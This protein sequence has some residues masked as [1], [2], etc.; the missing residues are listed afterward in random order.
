M[1][2]GSGRE[3]GATRGRGLGCGAGRLA[4]PRE[5]A[6]GPNCGMA[7]RR[8]TA[9][10]SELGTFLSNF[11]GISLLARALSDLKATKPAASALWQ[12]P[13]QAPSGKTEPGRGVDVHLNP[14]PA[15]GWLNPSR[16]RAR[17]TGRCTV[18]WR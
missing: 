12:R 16:A 18:H 10:A 17:S 14:G 11:K 4:G 7:A 6:G 13:V 8:D 2:V 3:A 9:R 15:A 5:P 1:R